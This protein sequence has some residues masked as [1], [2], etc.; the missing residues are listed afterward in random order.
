MDLY[1]TSR[2]RISRM[3]EKELVKISNRPN[4][5]NEIKQSKLKRSSHECKKQ[6]SMVQKV[7]QKNTKGKRPLDTLEGW[8]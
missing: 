2:P 5:V 4:I 7:L 6:N 1:M 8:N 3:E